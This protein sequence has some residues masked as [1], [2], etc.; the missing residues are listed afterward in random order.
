[1]TVDIAVKWKS[2]LKTESLSDLLCGTNDTD[3]AQF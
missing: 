3:D 2:N 1:M